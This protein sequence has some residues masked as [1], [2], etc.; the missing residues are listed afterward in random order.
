MRFV[1][2]SVVIVFTVISCSNSETSE[3]GKAPAIKQED[4]MVTASIPP[5]VLERG[6]DIYNK[7]CM[8]CHQADGSGNP[9]MYPPLSETRTVNGEKQKLISILLN[10]Q[11][12]EIE[13]KG[14]IYNGVMVPHNFLTDQQAADVLSYIRNS[15]G[16]N[17]GRIT[18]ED[19]ATVRAMK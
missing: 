19:I 9:G 17:A 7:H 8:A 18:E 15:F 3:T 11:T 4:K 6:M 12:G 14:E 10:G 13:V 5:A 16:N 1:L 2:I